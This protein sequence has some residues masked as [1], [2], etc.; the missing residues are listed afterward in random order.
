MRAP[1]YRAEL[2]A[3]R[4][5]L[6]ADDQMGTLFKVMGLAGAGWPRGVGFEDA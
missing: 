4:D 5:R 3:A 2:N 1:H 6:V